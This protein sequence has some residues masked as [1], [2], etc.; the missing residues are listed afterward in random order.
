MK[1]LT[2]TRRAW[3]RLVGMEIAILMVNDSKD[4]TPARLI[5][6]AQR[7]RFRKYARVN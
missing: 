5:P 7:A 4:L 3:A 6:R 1:K 2:R